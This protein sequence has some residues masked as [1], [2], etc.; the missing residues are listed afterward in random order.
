[1]ERRAGMTQQRTLDAALR[2]GEGLLGAFMGRKTST[3]RTGT[4]IRSAG[5]VMQQR[6]EVAQAEET[7][8]AVREQVAQL[9]QEFQDELRK[10]ELSFDDLASLEEV[11]IR[12]T[13]AGMAVRL[14]TLLWL[15]EDRG[16]QQLWR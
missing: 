9:E 7:V 1:V 5:R 13:L 4:A 10:V 2:V 14:C 11:Q 12:P 16:G 15:P 8:E 3:A 6:R